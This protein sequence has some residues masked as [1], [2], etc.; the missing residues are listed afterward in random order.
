[1]GVSGIVF[2]SAVL[3][4]LEATVGPYID[5]AIL[6]G[7]MVVSIAIELLPGIAAVAL[8][9][10]VPDRKGVAPATVVI[11][12]LLL[13][14]SFEYYRALPW[15]YA[16]GLGWRTAAINREAGSSGGDP[17]VP[18]YS[19]KNPIRFLSRKWNRKWRRDMAGMFGHYSDE[20]R[21]GELSAVFHYNIRAV[22]AFE[23][24]YLCRR[25]SMLP[26]D[27]YLLPIL[28]FIPATFEAVA[29]LV[30]IPLWAIWGLIVKLLYVHVSPFLLS[31]ALVIPYSSK[32]SRRR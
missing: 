5:I 15:R 9:R 14:C 3:D 7:F 2:G 29:Y 23:S 30:L 12:V 28:W 11:S 27:A 31:L 4:L 18:W 25:L 1:M 8:L 17:A 20:D 21:R 24:W 6:L 26:E 22:A 16:R 10:C 13:W 32:L 19:Q